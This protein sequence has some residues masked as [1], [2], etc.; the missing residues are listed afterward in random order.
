MPL[1][2]SVGG[3]FCSICDQNTVTKIGVARENRASLALAMWVGVCCPMEISPS[4]EQW[5][6]EKTTASTTLQAIPLADAVPLKP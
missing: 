5:L 4:T 3:A 2:S 1:Q 6:P